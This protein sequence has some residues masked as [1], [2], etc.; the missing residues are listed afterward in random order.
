MYWLR[1]E[2]ANTLLEKEAMAQQI[3]NAVT[4]E[5]SP[6]DL[7]S[8]IEGPL[9]LRDQISKH[10]T[11]Q[12]I[13]GKREESSARTK[14]LADHIGAL[15]SE[16]KDKKLDISQRKLELAQRYSDAESAKYHISERECATLTGIQNN[17]K[18][19]EH[20][21]HALHNRTAEARVFLCREAATLFGLR[22]LVEKINGELKET[23]IVGGVPIIH[24]RDMNGATPAHI[25]AALSNIAHLLVLVS[26]YLSLRLPA[27]IALAYRNH[28]T[29]SIYTPAA[30]YIS[31]EA[32]HIRVS[33]SQS[34]SSSQA[35]S[36]AASFRSNP[37]RPRPL[38]IDKNLPKL[39]K[40]DPMDYAL[41][42]E[43]AALLA[44]NI[45]WLCRTQ[46]LSLAS[47]SWEEVCDLGKNMWQLLVASPAQVPSSMRAFASRDVQS[48][49]KV[50]RD[51]PRTSIQRAKSF[52]MLGHYSHG[53]VHSFLGGSEGT[54][55][56]R[57]WKLPTP[58]RVVDKLRTTLLG[59]MASAEW[60]LLEKKEWDDE[61]HEQHQTVPEKVSVA[62]E[63]TTGSELPP[64]EIGPSHIV[65]VGMGVSESS[66][67]CISEQRV[68][69]RP[70]GTSGWTKLKSREKDS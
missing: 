52:P 2:N 25:S 14:I 5:N 59:E 48:K 4:S 62:T 45:S 10:W 27:E 29:P 53:T 47:D 65:L 24:L 31:H 50:S 33:P 8:H 66:Q 26:H 32:S 30:S 3:E 11:L 19:T 40:E 36:R 68:A 51:H 57:S 21:W 6:R 18:R 56:M 69:S 15:R 7:A 23:Y 39:A 20:I 60:E 16:I 43:G 35:I 1:I 42:L 9:K 64:E 67:K 61:V 55:F 22:Q 58:T 17:T 28:P 46:G 70:K 54:E 63:S 41:F 34:S 12:R 37:H 13:L 38:V 49:M 44:W